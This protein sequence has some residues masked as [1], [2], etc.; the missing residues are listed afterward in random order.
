[1]KKRKAAIPHT[2]SIPKTTSISPDK[3]PS[4]TVQKKTLKLVYAEF[5]SKT[6]WIEF[7]DS[8]HEEGITHFRESNLE[9]NSLN[10]KSQSTKITTTTPRNHR[11]QFQSRSSGKNGFVNANTLLLK[12]PAQFSSQQRDIEKKVKTQVEAQVQ[13][14]K[15]QYE[16]KEKS[17]QV[18]NEELKKENEELKKRKSE[19][20]HSL[21]TSTSPFVLGSKTEKHLNNDNQEWKHFTITMPILQVPKYD[22]TIDELFPPYDTFGFYSKKSHLDWE[23]EDF[24]ISMGNRG[25]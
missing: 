2:T 13:E 15:L 6:K 21:N 10:L 3:K 1:L 22:T 17:Y 4:W 7:L 12:S 18:E 9:I 14:I 8:L 16:Q 25:F 19:Y 24:G 11:K 23:I 5:Y 20:S